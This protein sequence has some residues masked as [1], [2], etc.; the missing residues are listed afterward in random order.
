VIYTY[1]YC[2]FTHMLIHG[3]SLE[4]TD[5]E[6][7]ALM[8]P[9]P[10]IEKICTIC[11]KPFTT[12]RSNKNIC[13]WECKREHNRQHARMYQRIARRRD[14]NNKK[15]KLACSVCGF[16]GTTDQHSENGKKYTLC[17]NHHCMIT[18]GIATLDEVL[19]MKEKDLQAPLAV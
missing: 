8:A 1:L 11:T 6:K 18:R 12:Q 3:H 7:N 4:F 10:H 19:N 13:S 9:S 14:L 2:N 16:S 5:E 17:P 15:I